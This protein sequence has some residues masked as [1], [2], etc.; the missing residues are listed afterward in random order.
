M[1]ERSPQL[2]KTMSGTLQ[3]DK[4]MQTGVLHQAEEKGG[5]GCGGLSVLQ[6]SHVVSESSQLLLIW[7]R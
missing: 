2:C 3:K 7:N 1:E 6:E 5:R 4:S